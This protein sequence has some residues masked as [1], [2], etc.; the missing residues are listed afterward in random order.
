MER[1]T[2]EQALL[3]Q[4]DLKKEIL[5]AIENIHLAAGMIEKNMC[6]AAR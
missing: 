2:V 5:D 1:I 4:Y 6:A 3:K